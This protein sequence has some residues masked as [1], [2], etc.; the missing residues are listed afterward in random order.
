MADNS[1]YASEMKGLGIEIFTIGFDL[2]RFEK[3]IQARQMLERCASSPRHFYDTD[4]ASIEGAF[5]EI[6]RI[7]RARQQRLTH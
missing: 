2:E 4:T 1:N 7:I 3:G 6:A 5:D